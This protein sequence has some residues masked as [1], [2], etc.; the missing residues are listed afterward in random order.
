MPD[1]RARSL[2]SAARGI[3]A[4]NAKHGKDGGGPFH[5]LHREPRWNPAEERFMGWERKRGKLE[6]LN[7]LLRGDKDTSYARHVGDPAGLVG[8]RFVITLDSDTQLPMGSARRLVGLL[9]HPLNRAVVRRR[10]RARRLRVHD[11]PAAHRDVSVELAPDAGSRGSSRATSAS[12]S[13][14][15]PSPSSYQDLFGAGIYVGKGIYDV[16][17]F[18]RSV[19]GRVP[20]NALVSHD[21]FEGI[22]G[23]TALATDIVLFEDY[24]SQLRRVRPA[25]A[26]VGARRLAAA[27]VAASRACPRRTA[28]GSANP[29][30][31]IDR[32]KIVDNL[33]RSLTSPLLLRAP[34]ARAGP[35]C[36][37][38]RCSGRSARS[39]SCSRRCLPALLRDRRRRAPRTSARCALAIAFLAHEA[40]GRR[41]RLIARVSCG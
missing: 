28:G 1:G 26:P 36:R 3:A 16:D 35:G 12:T 25:H 32:W 5:L 31:A 11:R 34:R 37:A 2:E 4:L 21:L 23:R 19:E 40:V 20:E 6:E 7:R 30:A 18:M 17:A 8:I 41:R 33:R 24:P 39:P 29:L 14:R 38:R 22:H 27:A 10:D 13:T 15:T 9:A